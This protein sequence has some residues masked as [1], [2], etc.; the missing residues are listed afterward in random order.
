[1]STPSTRNYLVA[2][3]LTLLAILRVASAQAGEPAPVL[4]PGDTWTFE[5]LVPPD[6]RE[7]WTDIVKFKT[8]FGGS[9]IFRNGKRRILTSFA[10]P[11]DQ[12]KQEIPM[13]R[14]PMSVGDSWEHKRDWQ[15][16]T[17]NLKLTITM[18]YKVVGH[19]EVIVPAGKFMT[20]KLA[21]DGWV[22]DNS[23]IGSVGGDARFEERYW[24]APEVKRIVKYHGKQL[25]WV[26]PVFMETWSLT[27]ELASYSLASPGVIDVK[28][29]P[30]QASE[31]EPTQEQEPATAESAAASEAIR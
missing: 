3:T 25:K 26:P 6:K 7:P 2:V 30:A 21:A 18:K 4:N 15:S 1:M 27:Y 20:Y 19:E 9:V 24:Y 23:S 22:K 8:P 13:L 16:V 28:T 31:P 10:N 5:N 11:R 14:F 29:T 17:G 12:V